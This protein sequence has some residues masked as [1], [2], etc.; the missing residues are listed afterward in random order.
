[1]TTKKTAAATIALCKAEGKTPVA[2]GAGGE[3]Y[4]GYEGYDA[5][6]AKLHRIGFGKKGYGAGETECC[7]FCGKLSLNP[8]Y[9]GFISSSATFYTVEEGES[10]DYIGFYPLGSDCAKRLKG[11]IPVYKSP[12]DG[13]WPGKEDLL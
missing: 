10:D 4:V 7:A 3:G 8:K 2:F 13:I 1:M 9:F 11:L 6:I 12:A 5:N